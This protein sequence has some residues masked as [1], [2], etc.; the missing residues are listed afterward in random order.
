MPEQLPERRVTAVA[1]GGHFVLVPG[2]TGSARACES[3][4]MR[5]VEVI[6][7]ELWMMR[8][9]DSDLEVQ[10]LARMILPGVCA[11]MLLRVSKAL[12]K[13]V[14]NARPAVPIKVKPQTPVARLEEGLA[15]LLRWCFIVAIDLS[16]WLKPGQLV[17]GSCS[18][19]DLEN[20]VIKAKGTGRLAAVLRQCPSLAHLNLRHNAIG[21][22]GARRLAA[23]LWQCPSLAHLDLGSNRIGN[24]GARRLAEVLGHRRQGARR[25][26]EVLGQCPSLAHLDLGN[27]S[28]EPRGQ[29]GWWRRSGSARRSPGSIFAATA[30]DIRIR[31]GCPCQLRQAFICESSIGVCEDWLEDLRRLLMCCVLS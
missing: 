4:L 31:G 14:E 5:A 17:E 21:A 25:L 10:E 3:E 24:E 30:S 7:H 6:P 22:G 23:V 20:K 18:Q 27:I 8:A 11:C 26:A 28:S 12:K 2:Q 15:R 13:A 16:E 19:G 1:H 29:D 9:L